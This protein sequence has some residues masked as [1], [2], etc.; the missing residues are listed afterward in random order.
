MKI[1]KLIGLLALTS[2]IFLT[3][4]GVGPAVK[5]LKKVNDETA[6]YW[7]QFIKAYG[8]DA[9]DQDGDLLL[10]WA[11]DQNNTALVKACIKSGANVNALNK[12][13]FTAVCYTVANNNFEATKMLINKKA[14]VVS[15]ELNLPYFTITKMKDEISDEIYDLIFK[16]IPKSYLDGSQF[17]FIDRKYPSLNTREN[18]AVAKITRRLIDNN[19]KAIPEDVYYFMNLLA[20]YQE[21][22]DVFLEFYNKYKYLIDYNTALGCISWG[23]TELVDLEFQLFKDLVQ[24]CPPSK[25][26]LDTISYALY[27]L[28]HTSDISDRYQKANEIVNI[29]K[30]NN[31]DIQNLNLASQLYGHY[32][33]TVTNAIADDDSYLVDLILNR[34]KEE[35]S[36][37][38]DL[39]N[40][41]VQLEGEWLGKTFIETYTTFINTY[42]K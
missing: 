5:E 20:Q 27:V 2:S 7:I 28:C 29:L 22:Q 12:R 33:I 10:T 15:N 30:S 32:V 4:C 31:W 9:I 21:N 8:I 25:E 3:S 35:F 41:G 19:Y 39:V 13:G 26:S 18:H 42:W 1:K 24:E 40:S 6:R 23:R 36:F 14:V 37:I 16:N 34:D 38:I 17:D 11:A